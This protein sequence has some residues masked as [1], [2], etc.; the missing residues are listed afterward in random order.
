MAGL[1]LRTSTTFFQHDLF[2][3]WDAA[4]NTFSGSVAG[5]LHRIDRFKTIYHRPTRRQKLSLAED[6]VVPA[7]G[8]IRH[9]KTGEVFLVSLL[10]EDEVWQGETVY[11]RLVTL[12][13]AVPYSG[14]YAVFKPVTV[15]GSGDDLGI[16]S[17]TNV[18]HAYVEVELRSASD[19]RGSLDVEIEE[20][21]LHLSANVQ[22][23]P[24]DYITF[25][26]DDYR[27]LVTFSDSGFRA[28]RAVKESPHYETLTYHLQTGTSSYNPATGTFTEGVADRLVSA[29][30]GD[31]TAMRERVSDQYSRQ[32]SVYIYQQHIGF[33][34]K[35]G[36]TFAYD[37]RTYTVTKVSQNQRELQWRLEAGL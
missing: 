31:E 13:R 32:L 15:S 5:R 17:L 19:E 24:G 9:A 27:I 29:L 1:D 11:E 25:D 8:V 21:T 26:G 2:V 4:T 16:V 18:Q 12:H 36:D 7:S 23:A 28:A 35:V 33:A 10:E 37:G 30:I 3:P 34:P 20:A 14:G 6:A 22:A